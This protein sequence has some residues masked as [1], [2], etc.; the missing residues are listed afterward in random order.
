MQQAGAIRG[1]TRGLDAR[2]PRGDSSAGRRKVDVGA[3]AA[4]GRD[5]AQRRRLGRRWL[6][7]IL[8]LFLGALASRGRLCLHFP[9]LLTTPELRARLPDARSCARP[10]RAGSRRRWRSAHWRCS[11]T[12][13]AGSGSRALALGLAAQ[14]AGGA[15]VEVADAGGGVE[16]PRPRLVRARPPAPRA[17]VRAARARLRAAARAA[18]LPARLAHRPR[19][20]L[21][22]PPAGA[23]DVAPHARAGAAALPRR[24]PIPARAGGA[25]PRCR[26]RSSSR[27]RSPWPTL[28]G[29]AAHRAFHAVPS[30]WR[31][32]A[33][34][35]SSEALD[36]L[37]GSRLH[38]VDVVAT[39]AVVFVPLFAAR[40][41]ARRARRLPRLGRRSRRPGSTPTCALRRAR[42]RRCSRR[43]AST[44]GTTRPTPRPR[45]RN[46]AVHLPL[47]DRLFGTHHLPRRALARALRHRTA[48]R[49]RRGWTRAA[50][51]AA[52]AAGGV[53]SPG[54][55]RCP[56]T[57]AA[58]A[59]LPFHLRGNYAPVAEEVTAFDLPVE[60]AIPPALRGLYL[61]N[62][63]NPKPGVVAATGSSATACCTACASRTA[64]PRWYRNRYVRTRVLEDRR[65][66]SSARTASVDSHVGRRQHPRDRPRGPHPRARRERRS[67]PSVDREL[68]TRRRLRLRRPAHDRDDGAPEALPADRR[69]ALLRLRLRSRPSSPT[70]ASTPPGASC[71]ARRSTVPRPTMIH[72]FAITE[73]HVVLHGPAASSSTSSWRCAGGMPYQWSDELRRAPRRHAARAAAP[74]TC[75]GSRSSPATSSIR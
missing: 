32:H 59:E 66:R 69:A 25:S 35:H 6:P 49:C 19:P 24:P 74:P 5:D 46:F 36:W 39:R 54:A 9:A 3:M 33:V 65:R 73:R 10:S 2:R 56:M 71:R 18:G 17:R 26:S 20:L 1:P 48:S 58:P 55:W 44:T 47:I 34:H 23:A 37:A 64:A 75:A 22:E 13:A 40:L 21:R 62:G 67:R 28:A 15:G 8:A 4:D 63:P 12:P 27:S 38:L 57:S 61:R 60:G 31:F 42:S 16:P 53:G 14:L 45:D 29:Y 72:D 30:L 50:R 68:E 43:R 7:G 11:P 51:V 52:P 70:T 41:R